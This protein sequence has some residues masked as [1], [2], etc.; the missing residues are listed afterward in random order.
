MIRYKMRCLINHIWISDH[1]SDSCQG[2]EDCNK[3]TFDIVRIEE[4]EPDDDAAKQTA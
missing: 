1:Y 4:K 3:A 2:K